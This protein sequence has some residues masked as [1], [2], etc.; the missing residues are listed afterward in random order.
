MSL[1]LREE[2][3]GVAGWR[4]AEAGSHHKTNKTRSKGREKL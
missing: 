3:D 4:D 2:M 1:K